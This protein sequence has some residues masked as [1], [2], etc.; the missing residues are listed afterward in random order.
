MR[1]TKSGR[2]R[3]PVRRISASG[4]G[5]RA[6]RVSGRAVEAR[7]SYHALGLLLQRARHRPRPPVPHGWAKACT[8]A[9]LPGRLFHDLRRSAARNF[10]RAGIPRSVAMKLGGWTDKMYSRYAIGAESEIAPMVPKL[11]EYFSRAGLASP[12]ADT[13]T[14]TDTGAKSPIESKGIVAEK[15]RS[16][17]FPTPPGGAACGLGNTSGR[18]GR[19]R[20]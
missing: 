1:E 4:R 11:S 14:F 8:S 6:A 15:G 12:S 9:G 7:R 10:E 16:R 13:D 19:A 2:P 5:H 3:D 17:S 20:R 18:S